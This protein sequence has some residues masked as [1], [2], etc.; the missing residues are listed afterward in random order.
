M[1]DVAF[2][3]GVFVGV[4]LAAFSGWWFSWIKMHIEEHRARLQE[5]REAAKDMRIIREELEKKKRR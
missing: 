3:G 1:I 4:V 2:L 5:Q